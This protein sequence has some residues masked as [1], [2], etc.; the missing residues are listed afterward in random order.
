VYAVPIELLVEG[1]IAAL[2]LITIGF[3]I[4]LYRRLGK[5]RCEEHRLQATIAELA[6]A[7]ERA[8]TAIFHLSGLAVEAEAVLAARTDGAGQ[9]ADELER[10]V[11][12]AETVLTRI[13][14]IS[15][16]V[17]PDAPRPAVPRQ[18]SRGEEA[19]A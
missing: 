3:C 13:I 12:A 19:A 4:A 16:A 8:E 7:G 2:L 1:F 5:L 6:E 17:R 11:S 14:A 9:L 15:R 10:Q 18:A